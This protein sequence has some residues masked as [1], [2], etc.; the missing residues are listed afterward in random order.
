MRLE[1]AASRF[2]VMHSTTEPLHS[3]KAAVSGSS[4]QLTLK[5][6]APGDQ[7]TDLL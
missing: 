6:G 2:Q 1:P 5:K 4:R 7:V 3:R